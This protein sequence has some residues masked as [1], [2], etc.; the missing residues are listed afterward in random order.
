MHPILFE[1]PLFGGITIYTY[2]VLT[3]LGFLSGMMWV[4]YE[5][6]RVGANADRALD[7]VFY[8]IVASILGARATYVLVSDSSQFFSDPLSFFRIWEGGLVYYGGFIGALA[9]TIWYTHRH[10]M[11][12]LLYADILATALPLGHAIGRLGCIMAGCCF[13]RPRAP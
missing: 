10:H 7:L 3:A 5:A 1:I 13:W 8:I 2:G 9:M 4:N 12:F 6:K 11:S